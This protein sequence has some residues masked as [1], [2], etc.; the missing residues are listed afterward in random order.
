MVNFQKS[1]RTRFFGYPN[2]IPENVHKLVLLSLVL[3][4]CMFSPEKKTEIPAGI[5]P[6]TYKSEPIN[7]S[8]KY[9]YADGLI[10]EGAVLAYI[11]FRLEVNKTYTGSMK[12]SFFIS[13]ETFDIET[14]LNGNWI[15][16][17]GE[18]CLTG[19]CN[20]VKSLAATS[21]LMFFDMTG[22]QA[23]DGFTYEMDF[24]NWIRM[25]KQ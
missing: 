6:G 22:Q 9:T 4:S 14:P 24:A 21:F 10:I 2:K 1:G 25:V 11:N 12:M 5:G 13:G 17:S 7:S 18:L 23:G 3:T 16:R 20:P 15:H 8:L 19:D